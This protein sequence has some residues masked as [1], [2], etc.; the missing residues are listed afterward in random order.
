MSNYTMTAERCT[1]RELYKRADDKLLLWS[2]AVA[3]NDDGSAHIVRTH[4]QRGGKI[5]TAAD[6]VTTG[7]NLGKK[8]ETTPLDQAIAEADAEWELKQRRKGYSTDPDTTPAQYLPMLAQS[9]KAAAAKISFWGTAYCQ[10]KY[11]GFRC[12]ATWDAKQKTVTLRSRENAVFTTMPHV[13]A[14]IAKFMRATK[15]PST[16]LDGELY[17]HSLTFTQI[18]SAIKNTGKARSK[19]KAVDARMI[20][21]H[22]Y[23]EQDAERTFKERYV[24][25]L[26]VRL[27]QDYGQDRSILSDVETLPVADHDELMELQRQF[28]ADGYEG[29]MLR[30]GSAVYEHN[31]RSRGLIKV[32]TFDDDEFRVVEVKAGRGKYAQAAVFGCRTKRGHYFDVLAPG[33]VPQKARY[34][35]NASQWMGKLLT[36]KYEGYTATE[37]PVP[38]N[39]VAVRFRD[40][41]VSSKRTDNSKDA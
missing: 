18:S 7:K 20:G 21:Y 13:E 23:D 33:S 10:R 17:S 19:G 6:H 24:E 39:P 38:R 4:G 37:S 25:S 1:W 31:K 16:T 36:V 41:A 27:Q 32:K 30:D 8:N 28:I 15:L 29:A 34:L 35:R 2:I 22:C 3:I 14:E 9:Y 26:A 40:D 12:L 11:D 5:Q